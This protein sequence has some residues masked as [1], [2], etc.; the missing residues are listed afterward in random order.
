MSKHILFVC[1]SCN[2]TAETKPDEKQADG[3]ALLT[4]GELYLKSDDGLVS[5]YKLPEVLQVG[6]VAR[7]PPRPYLEKD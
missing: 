4:L 5:N 6:R 1:K 7:I 2:A 3:S